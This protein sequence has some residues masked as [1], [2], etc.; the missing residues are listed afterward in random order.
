MSYQ[1]V[2]STRF[3]QSYQLFFSGPG[4]VQ[5]YERCPLGFICKLVNHHATNP[6]Y[7]QCHSIHVNISLLTF[8]NSGR[9]SQIPK[10]KYVTYFLFF[11]HCHKKRAFRHMKLKSWL[12]TLKVSNTGIA[13]MLNVLYCSLVQSK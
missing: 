7:F 6:P 13:K 9:N 5:C 11:S 3:W 8:R 10:F 4:N 2:S 1:W 12:S